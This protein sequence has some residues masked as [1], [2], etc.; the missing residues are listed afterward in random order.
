MKKLYLHPPLNAVNSVMAYYRRHLIYGLNVLY[1]YDQR[2][3]PALVYA[4][5][6][7][8]HKRTTTRTNHY[9]LNQDTA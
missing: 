3:T 8:H 2:P 9:S 6:D 7:M 4:V 5:C 1:Y